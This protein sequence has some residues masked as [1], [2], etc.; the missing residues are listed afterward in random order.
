MPDVTLEWLSRL[1][2]GVIGQAAEGTQRVGWPPIFLLPCSRSGPGITVSCLKEDK[3]P[4]SMAHILVGETDY[5][6]IDKRI[7][8]DDQSAEYTKTGHQRKSEH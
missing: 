6:H 8:R 7:S 5:R 3:G 2:F 4:A 1:H